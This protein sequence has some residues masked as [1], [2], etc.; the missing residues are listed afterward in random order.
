VIRTESFLRKSLTLRE[1]FRDKQPPG[2]EE[3]IVT[4]H[5]ALA[6]VSLDAVVPLWH[7]LPGNLPF[8][9]AVNDGPDVV[10]LSPP[11]KAPGL[12]LRSI[13][14]AAAYR[15]PFKPHAPAPGW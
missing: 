4:Q 2:V 14:L 11:T 9:P 7:A 10:F 3:L 6:L 1:V 12:L 13:F 15:D 5:K 8:I